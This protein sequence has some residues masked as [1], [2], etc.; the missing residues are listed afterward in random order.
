MPT[1]SLLNE[2]NDDDRLVCQDA[3]G[4]MF[5]F[6]KAGYKSG[7]RVLKILAKNVQLMYE[8]IF[9]NHVVH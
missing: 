1:P 5:E 8:R 4:D 2:A 6:S 7:K 3:Q 9:Y